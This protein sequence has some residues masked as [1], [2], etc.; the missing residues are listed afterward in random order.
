MTRNRTAVC[1]WAWPA[2]AAAL[3]AC[4]GAAHRDAGESRT[5]A[6]SVAEP[7]PLPD[8]TRLLNLDASVT[9]IN[10]AAHGSCIAIDADRRSRVVYLMLPAESSYVRL[11]VVAPHGSVD[12]VDLVRGIPDGRIWSATFNASRRSATARL[13]ASAND[14]A[15]VTTDW[16][17]GDPRLE[18][19][20]EVAGTA[21]Q[22]PC[23]LQ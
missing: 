16:P 14:K 11:A 21:I 4:D 18:R 22:A 2:M 20:L 1:W 17:A 13:F 3:A 15:P 12:V 23:T 6:I 8:V 7:A 5:P 19:L 9:P 10:V